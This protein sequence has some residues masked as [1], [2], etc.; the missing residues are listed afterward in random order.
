M[1]RQL[2]WRLDRVWRKLQDGTDRKPTEWEIRNAKARQ[3]HR[4]WVAKNPEKAR[5][6]TERTTI[7]RRADK[8]KWRA[9]S[10]A[11][12]A[13]HRELGRLE[14]RARAAKP[15]VRARHRERARRWAMENRERRREYK[16]Q[17]YA[18]ARGKSTEQTVAGQ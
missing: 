14:A 6:Q 13:K 12:Y 17:W 18:L 15:E 8:E 3:Y 7:Q 5:A 1:V 16:R 11:H 9:Y 4:E 10:R 2:L